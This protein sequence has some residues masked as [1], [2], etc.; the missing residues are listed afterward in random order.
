MLPYI[1]VE[2]FLTSDDFSGYF[3]VPQ[4]DVLTLLNPPPQPPHLWALIPTWAELLPHR[5]SIHKSPQD[6][7]VHDL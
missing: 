4:H 7:L 1:T 5:S 3:E 6:I 2:K